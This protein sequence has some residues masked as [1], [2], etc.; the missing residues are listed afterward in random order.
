MSILLLVTIFH[1][2]QKAGWDRT[3]SIVAV[4][5]F[6]GVRTVGTSLID[7]EERFM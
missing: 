6:L 4:L 7:I 5:A 2:T 3:A 1:E